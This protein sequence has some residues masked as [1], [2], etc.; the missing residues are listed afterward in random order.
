MNMK[1]S[2][3]LLAAA[4]IMVSSVASAT[5]GP[6]GITNAQAASYRACVDKVRKEIPDVSDNQIAAKYFITDACA[7]EAGAWPAK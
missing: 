1:S 3:F 2:I 5:Q 6:E 4:G 7:R